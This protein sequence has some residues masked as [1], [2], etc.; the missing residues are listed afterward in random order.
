M[1]RDQLA[2]QLTIR[3]GTMIVSSFGSHT[4]ANLKKENDW[5]TEVDIAVEKMYRT[6]ISAA[7]PDD[8][9]L[10]EENGYESGTTG[11]TWVIDPLDGT[12][13]FARGIPINGSILALMK[14]DVVVSGYIILPHNSEFYYAHKGKG[15]FYRNLKTNEVRQ[16]N[17]SDRSVAEG[18]FSPSNF[19]DHDLFVEDMPVI[20]RLHEKMPNIRSLY[21]A[22]YGFAYVAAGKI[23]ADFSPRNNPWDIAAGCL[24]V[25][26]AGG[27]VT[28]Y[29]GKP[30]KRYDRS[31]VVSNGVV[32][33][34][35]I[36]VLKEYR[37][38]TLEL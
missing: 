5:V 10:G 17:V 37:S 7:F 15:S 33:D 14:D 30:L 2:E 29:Y 13:N 22:A 28:D 31:A 21:C 19:I 16:I 35:I 26:E 24:I 18:M 38:K 12:N 20:S 11:Y 36:E 9:L 3:A 34:A 6:E 27:R 23:E 32:H 8:A 25:E 4:E 1:E